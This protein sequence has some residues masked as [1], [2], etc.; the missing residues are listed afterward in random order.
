MDPR[1]PRVDLRINPLC[2]PAVPPSTGFDDSTDKCGC[3]RGESSRRRLTV[4]HG[5]GLDSW[6]RRH[7]VLLAFEHVIT[8]KLAVYSSVS[9]I[10]SPGKTRV[11]SRAFLSLVPSGASVH[12]STRSGA[13]SPATQ[14]RRSV[15]RRMVAKFR[16]TRVKPCS[17]LPVTASLAPASGTP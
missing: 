6:I 5:G 13:P 16:P 2:Q 12:S 3:A 7:S 8:T 4:D 15:S 17:M 14:W 9:S 1:N 11:F 10:A